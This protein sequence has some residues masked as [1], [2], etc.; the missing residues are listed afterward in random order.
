MTMW[1]SSLTLVNQAVIL[2]ISYITTATKSSFFWLQSSLVFGLL[3]DL[4]LDF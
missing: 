3:M 2:T 1:E 4:G